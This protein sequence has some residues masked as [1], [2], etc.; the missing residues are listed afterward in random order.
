MRSRLDL[1]LLEKPNENKKRT[2]LCPID[3]PVF[4]LP[5][6]A[7]LVSYCPQVHKGTCFVF[8]ISSGYRILTIHYH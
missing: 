1:P 7:D 5:D 4:I 3:P 6:R 8:G 2:H